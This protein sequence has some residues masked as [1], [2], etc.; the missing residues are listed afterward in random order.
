MRCLH[1]RLMSHHLIVDVT[2]DMD[3][4]RFFRDGIVMMISF[5]LEADTCK[6]IR[7]KFHD[8][9]V[10]VGD[11]RWHMAFIHLTVNAPAAPNHFRIDRNT[12]IPNSKHTLRPIPN[13]SKLLTNFA[14]LVKFLS[15]TEMRSGVAHSPTLPLSHS[16]TPNSAGHHNLY[17]GK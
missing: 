1:A 12:P 5:L 3:F 4:R 9:H 10:T 7:D 6:I 13:W 2:L 16:P 17:I 14:P 8:C 15:S 11:A